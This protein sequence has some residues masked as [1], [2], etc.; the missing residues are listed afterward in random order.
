MENTPKSAQNHILN[1][2]SNAS[3]VL[4]YS[5]TEIRK[6]Y[7]EM[8]ICLM[9]YIEKGIQENI[10]EIRFDDGNTTL[11]CGFDNKNQCNICYLFFDD[12]KMINDYILY[13]ND[14]HDYDFIQSRWILP[15]CYLK[16][17]VMKD[18]TCFLFYRLK[19]A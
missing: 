4:D 2:I 16:I 13:L 6:K 8:P 11:S 14:K 9:E 1:L 19:T 17:K 7:S 3:S 5:L 12:L 10:F 15:N 18:D